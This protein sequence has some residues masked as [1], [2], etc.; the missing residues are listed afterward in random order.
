MM[1]DPEEKPAGVSVYQSGSGSAAVCA[2]LDLPI[3]GS[4]ESPYRHRQFGNDSSQARYLNESRSR[5][6]TV[7]RSRTTSRSCMSRFC[8]MIR[9]RSVIFGILNG[10][11]FVRLGNVKDAFGVAFT[12]RTGHWQGDDQVLKRRVGGHQH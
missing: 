12:T 10:D 2:D 5:Q 4:V 9:S 8:R 7:N 6:T 3:R 1:R 11:I